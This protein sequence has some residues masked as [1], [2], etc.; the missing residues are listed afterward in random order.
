MRTPCQGEGPCSC[1]RGPDGTTALGV[2]GWHTRRDEHGLCVCATVG[3]HTVVNW[4]RQNRMWASCPRSGSPTVPNRRCTPTGCRPIPAMPQAFGLSP[5]SSPEAI[6]IGGTAGATLGSD[7][8]SPA[9]SAS[10]D[11]SRALISCVRQSPRDGLASGRPLP[12]G[13]AGPARWLSEL[14]RRTQPG[15][16]AHRRRRQQNLIRSTPCRD[17]SSGIAIAVVDCRSGAAGGA[18]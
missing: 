13:L 11:G 12:S 16:A 8:K 6:P 4:R 1:A 3:G 7:P 14:R 10:T 17:R 2:Y 5:G 15:P 9:D 18:R